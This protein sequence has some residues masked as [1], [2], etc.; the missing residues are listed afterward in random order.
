MVKSQEITRPRDSLRLAFLAALG[1]ILWGLWV[2]W[3]HGV[4]ARFQVAFTQGAISLV[5]TYYS[6]ELVVWMV[7]KF[8]KSKFT[9]GFAG[10]ASYLIIYAFVW[11][12]HFIAGTPELLVTMLPGMITGLFFCVGY[13]LRVKRYSDSKRRISGEGA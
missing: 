7:R 6:A 11:A 13:A 9:V 12:G 1:F 10:A 3:E 4:G 2:N 8:W 5:S